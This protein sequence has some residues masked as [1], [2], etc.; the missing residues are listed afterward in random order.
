LAHDVPIERPSPRPF[1]VTV[2]DFTIE[3]PSHDRPDGGEIVAPV[4][5]G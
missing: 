4:L 1:A 3:L 2:S 5:G